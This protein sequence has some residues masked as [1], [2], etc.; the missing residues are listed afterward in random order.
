[1]DQMQL[2]RVR[3]E[4]SQRLRVICTLPAIEGRSGKRRDASNALAR[5]FRQVAK[6]LRQSVPAP[7][8]LVRKRRNIWSKRIPNPS[9][10]NGT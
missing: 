7:H 1:M 4:L 10:D 8:S 9:L 5:F 3:D 2:R 6:L